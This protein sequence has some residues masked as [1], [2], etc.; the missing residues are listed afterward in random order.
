MQIPVEILISYH[1]S[2]SGQFCDHADSFITLNEIVRARVEK[3]FKYFG[4]SEHM[5]RDNKKYFYSEEI[6][7]GR[8]PEIMMRIF[9][10]YVREAKRLKEKWKEEVEILVGFETD[11]CDPGYPELVNKIRDEF[12]IDYIVGSVHHVDGIP[13]DF[14]KETYQKAVAHSGGLDELFAKYYEH[15]YDLIRKCKPEVI[16][17]FDLIKIFAEKDFKKS[18]ATEKL[19]ERNI[20]EVI[21]Y[22]G[23]F[24]IN[25]R[26]FEK[27]LLEPYPGLEIL[28]K[29]KE[30]GGE[31]TLGDD[32]HGIDDIGIYFK[33]AIEFAKQAGL[34]NLTA[35]TKD[36]KKIKINI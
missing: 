26:A 21:S 28:R 31:I 1:G 33:K 23:I 15:Q 32:S 5:P 7:K 14:D 16:G 25:P 22:G 17:H 30:N 24:E 11:Y 12:G 27:N 4:L 35:F 18:A 36:L 34:K 19:I 20:K 13:I 9:G 2:H 6:E 10:E 29:I 8:T 3:G